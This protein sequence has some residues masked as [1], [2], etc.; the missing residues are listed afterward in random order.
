MADPVPIK[1]KGKETY[2]K[3]GNESDISGSF[4]LDGSLSGVKN[5][6]FVGKTEVFTLRSSNN[7]G[8]SDKFGNKS[9]SSSNNS[10][11][12]SNSDMFLLNSDN[13]NFQID[14]GALKQNLRE[15]KSQAHVLVHKLSPTY[16][17]SLKSVQES[18]RI[19]HSNSAMYEVVLADIREIFGDVAHIVRP[20]T[21]G[22]FFVG[23][24]TKDKFEGPLGCN[25][26]CAAALEPADHNFAPCSHTVLLYEDGTFVA[27][28]NNKSTLAYISVDHKF[29]GFTK[30]NID[31]LR[32][33]GIERV[34][35]IYGG[36][37]A[38][39]KK[40][41]KAVCIEELP[42]RDCHDNGGDSNGSSSG[43]AVLFVILLI[44]IIIALLVVLYRNGGY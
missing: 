2:T 18:I 41:N 23:C 11:N 9:F 44:I 10:N 37:N 6:E 27:L 32:K 7:V 36:A 17:E 35:L 4:N 33:V 3:G 28:N 34:I 15:L 12:S 24:A 8:N 38:E 31:Q 21:V 40:V 26:K 30:A 22:A 16:N 19:L 42:I 20:G 43:A 14:R 39:F 29:K 1:N 13:G 5:M 25:P